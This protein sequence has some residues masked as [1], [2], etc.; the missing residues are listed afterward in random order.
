MSRSVT[1]ASVLLLLLTS[2]ALA[3]SPDRL[4]R[5]RMLPRVSVLHESGGWLG[6]IDY[7]VSGAFG[8]ARTEHG[9]L[10]SFPRAELWGSII[11]DGPVIAIAKDVDEALQ[12]TSLNGEL[13]PTGG[14]F[15]VYRFRESTDGGERIQLFAALLGPWMYLRGMTDV[16]PNWND[17][18][19]YTFR[20]L[21]RTGRNG[22]FNG[23]GS[24]DSADYTAY[25]DARA[26]GNLEADSN[27]DGLVNR[28]DYLTWREQYGQ[29]APDFSDVDAAITA[30][31]SAEFSAGLAIAAPEPASAVLV[32]LG[33]GAAILRR[34]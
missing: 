4:D 32:F 13:L 14:P 5:Y 30:A 33:I 9:T 19:E 16:P 26:S 6:E 3:Q 23:D 15:D 25:R 10:A 28:E 31:L 22:D 11:S 7:R 21:A 17:Y 24:V 27:E 18:P 1:V 2:P 20:G 34:R 29:Q 8:F 12:L